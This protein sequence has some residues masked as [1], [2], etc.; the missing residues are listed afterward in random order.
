MISVSAM[1]IGIAS[2]TLFAP[3]NGSTTHSA[4]KHETTT[5]IISQRASVE[6][7]RDAVVCILKN[8]SHA[9]AQ[10]RKADAKRSRSPWVFFAPL[11]LCVRNPTSISCHLKSNRITQHLQ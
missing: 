8:I 9:K 11:R 7:L 2:R 10:R 3:T 4:T 6:G 1:A 5:E